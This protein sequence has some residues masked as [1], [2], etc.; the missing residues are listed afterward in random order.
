MAP[1]GNRTGRGGTQRFGGAPRVGGLQSK[2]SIIKPVRF[3]VEMVKQIEKKIGRA[4]SFSDY[5]RECVEKDLK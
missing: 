2:G 5:V 1:K 4:K 3:S